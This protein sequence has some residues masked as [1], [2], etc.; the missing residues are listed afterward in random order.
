[1]K[2]FLLLLLLLFIFSCG[3][4]NSN[5]FTTVG[6]GT[7]AALNLSGI[8]TTIAGKAEIV[9][10]DDGAGST[11]RFGYEIYTTTDGTNLYISDYNNHK[12]Q[13]LV[14]AIGVVATIAGS[15]GVNG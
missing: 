13:K 4:N 10:T 7:E 5:K 1:M 14:I 12:V 8:V 3:S 9:G 15:A 6:Y 2:L 11:A